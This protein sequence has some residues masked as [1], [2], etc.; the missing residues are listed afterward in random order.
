MKVAIVT[1]ASSGMGREFVKQIAANYLFLD[2]IWVIGRN[3]RKLF[4]LQKEVAKKIRVLQLDLRKREGQERLKIFLETE[5]P[6]IKLLVNSAGIGKIGNFNEL[7]LNTQRGIVRLNCEAL[8]AVTYLCLPYMHC[9]TRV[10]QMASAAAFIPQPGFA[11][12][13]ASKSYVL[14][15]S[16]ALRMELMERGITVTSVCPG[17]VNT[18]FFEKAE[19][20]H[21]M[22]DLKKASMVEPEAVVEKAIKDAAIGR[23]MSVYGGNMKALSLICK[24]IPH[25]FLIWLMEYINHFE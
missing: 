8:T 17:P 3:R 6:R 4:D 16:R 20:L 11:V 21:A 7:S 24:V 2:E 23:A 25:Q 15:F 18:P 13:A 5:N 12:Y 1:G 9:G 22:A 19:Q 10:I 14:S